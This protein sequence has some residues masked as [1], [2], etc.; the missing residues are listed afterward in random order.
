MA[1]LQ[2]FIKEHLME[3]FT[4]KDLSNHVSLTPSYVCKLF[5]QV[6]GDT[7]TYYTHKLKTDKAIEFLSETNM[8]LSEIAETLGFYDQFHF[9]KVFKAHVGVPPSKYRSGLTIKGAVFPIYAKRRNSRKKNVEDEPVA[10]E[11]LK[12]SE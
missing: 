7:I 9:S 12:E 6:T 2:N 1:E 5:K 11:E 4:L 3:P 10:E 8:S